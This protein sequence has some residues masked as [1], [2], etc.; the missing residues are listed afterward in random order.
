MTDADE[1]LKA[2]YVR[3]EVVAALTVLSLELSVRLD[4]E[5]AREFARADSFDFLGLAEGAREL[6]FE[7]RGSLGGGRS[8]RGLS[9]RF[10]TGCSG[11]VDR[12]T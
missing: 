4:L 12:N 3:Y 2:G 9:S 6:A 7:L 8:G 5:L 10:M 1:G 11:A